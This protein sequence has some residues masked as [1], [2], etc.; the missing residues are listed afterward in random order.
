MGLSL[1]ILFAAALIWYLV[2][3]QPDSNEPP[4]PGIW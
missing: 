3:T 2:S 1:L 4:H